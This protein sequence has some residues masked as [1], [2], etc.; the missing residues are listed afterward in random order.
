MRRVAW[1]PSSQVTGNPVT[2]SL[3]KDGREVKSTY[4]FDVRDV[5]TLL[6]MYTHTLLLPLDIDS[7]CVRVT[8]ENDSGLILR[9]SQCDVMIS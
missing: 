1:P 9:S 5:L 6:Y 4:L 2:W 3:F 7:K 8:G